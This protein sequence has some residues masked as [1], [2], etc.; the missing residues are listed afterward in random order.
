MLL[1][2]QCSYEG[3]DQLV[4]EMKV[5]PAQFLPPLLQ[6]TAPTQVWHGQALATKFPQFPH[7]MFFGNTH[8]WLSCPPDEQQPPLHCRAEELSVLG[9]WTVPVAAAC[10]MLA[11]AL[12]CGPPQQAVLKRYVGRKQFR[13][14]RSQVQAFAVT[15]HW[16]APCRL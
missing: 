5:I 11:A 6:H 1:L 2:L 9:T 12:L 10:P 13:G 15:V 7:R 16:H 4:F 3:L 8:C 14:A